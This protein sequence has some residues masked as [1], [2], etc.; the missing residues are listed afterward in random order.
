VAH[1]NEGPGEADFDFI[2]GSTPDGRVLLDFRGMQINHLKMT[3]DVALNL[4]EGL[5]EAV[6]QARQGLVVSLDRKF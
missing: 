3:Q 4:A 6:N 2:V 5:V 1:G